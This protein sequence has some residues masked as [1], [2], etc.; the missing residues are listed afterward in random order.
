[1]DYYEMVMNRLR[2]TANEL[3]AQPTAIGPTYFIMTP[4][5]PNRPIKIWTMQDRNM[6]LCN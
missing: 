2:L 6:M 1:M 3:I 4:G 5:M